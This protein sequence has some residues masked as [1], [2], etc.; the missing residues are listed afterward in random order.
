MKWLAPLYAAHSKCVLRLHQQRQ[1]SLSFACPWRMGP[2]LNCIQA[3][4][5]VR[6]VED[7]VA[8][9]CRRAAGGTGCTDQPLNIRANIDAHARWH[10]LRDQ[11]QLNRYIHLA[12]RRLAQLVVQRRRHAPRLLRPATWCGQPIWNCT[13]KAVQTCVHVQQEDQVVLL[14][15]AISRRIQLSTLPVAQQAAAQV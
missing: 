10:A 14:E 13:E 15:L 3:V 1:R 7:E 11:R 2:H 5:L 4:A 9:R 8:V 12:R 6:S